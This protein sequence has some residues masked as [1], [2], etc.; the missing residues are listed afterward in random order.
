MSKFFTTSDHITKQLD[1]ANSITYRKLSYGARQKLISKCSAV[2]PFTQEASIDFS[3]LSLEIFKARMVSWDGPDFEGFPCT[4]ANIEALEQETAQAILALMGETNEE[5][6][7][8]E[9]KA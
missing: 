5:L 7:A 4:P 3:L 6:D 9:K 8:D 1:D 2:N